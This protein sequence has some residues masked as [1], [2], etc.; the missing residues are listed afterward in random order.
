MSNSNRYRSR[1][2][3]NSRIKRTKKIPKKSAST[4][5]SSDFRSMLSLNNPQNQ[6]YEGSIFDYKS[7]KKLHI[8]EMVKIYFFLSDIYLKNTVD[9]LFPWVI[10]KT[11]LLC[12]IF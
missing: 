10:L 8:K 3:K 2:H 11:E 9:F 5:N 4:N 12:G 7:V 6:V 1:K